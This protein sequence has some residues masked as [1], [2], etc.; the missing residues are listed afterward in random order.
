CVHHFSPSQINDLT[1]IN[2]TIHRTENQACHTP[3]TMRMISMAT[4][5]KRKDRW[6]VQIRRA[7]YP[8]ISKTFSRHTDALES[9]RN[10]DIRA[11]R[12]DLESFTN[13][14]AKDATVSDMLEKY[15]TEV[16]P[17]KPSR[18]VQTYILR[19]FQRHKLAQKK[20][21]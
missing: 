6:Q 9:A 14:E 15:I 13:T 7:G 1:G 12:K 5:R 21:C 18:T 4:I 3:V 17:V 19:R 16:L 11:D 8:V 20:V 2:G 10:M